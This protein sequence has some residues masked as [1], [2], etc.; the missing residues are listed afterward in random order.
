MLLCKNCGSYNTDPGGSPAA[1]KCG[2]C[3]Q[4][5]LVRLEPGA[6]QRQ[7]RNREMTAAAFLGI[8]IGGAIGGA[9]GAAIGALVGA[10]LVGASNGSSAPTKPTK[11]VS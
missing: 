5:A 8:G 4:S 10:G 9:I 2:S 11:H 1:F 3:G 7:Q 6:Q